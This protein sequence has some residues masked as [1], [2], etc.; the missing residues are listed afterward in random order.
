[1]QIRRVHARLNP[2][3]APEDRVPA[4]QDDDRR[5][6][7]VDL[8][9]NGRT[10][11]DP[12]DVARVVAVAVLRPRIDRPRCRALLDNRRLAQVVAEPLCVGR[13]RRVQRPLGQDPE[14][15]DNVLVIVERSL[16][17][18]ERV[19]RPVAGI[20]ARQHPDG[21]GLQLGGQVGCSLV[22]RP[23]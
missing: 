10:L 20:K 14:Q 19:Q 12:E 1:M 6:G 21:R 18:A 13:Q 5:A 2:S 8:Q 7:V 9:A 15:A 22:A 4:A 17:P 16:G 23:P 3:R 11:G